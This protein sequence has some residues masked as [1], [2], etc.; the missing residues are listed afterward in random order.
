VR[1]TSGVP[2]FLLVA[3]LV[4]LTPAALF[5]RRPTDVDRRLLDDGD[6]DSAVISI[7]RRVRHW[8]IAGPRKRAAVGLSRCRSHFGR[9]VIVRIVSPCCFAPA[10]RR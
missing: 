1:H 8:G 3:L 4:G 7:R 9:S 6:F 5:R 2:L 10:L